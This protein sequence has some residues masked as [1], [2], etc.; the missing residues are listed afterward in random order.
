MSLNL[1]LT[2]LNNASFHPL[3]NLTFL[4]I[5][6]Q[7][8]ILYNHWLLSFLK[9]NCLKIF[10]ISKPQALKVLRKPEPFRLTLRAACTRVSGSDAA[11]PAVCVNSASFWHTGA[12][13]MPSARSPPLCAD[14]R[15]AV[16]LTVAVPTRSGRCVSCRW[17]TS[18]CYRASSRP[19]WIWRS[20]LRSSVSEIK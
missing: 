16:P 4:L 12:A 5:W 19:P 7:G 17:P 11:D 15:H 2:W 8:K 3:T 18:C 1:R 20:D 14:A 10:S 13:S 6:R 9:P